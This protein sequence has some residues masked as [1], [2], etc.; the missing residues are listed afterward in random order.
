[1]ILS[2]PEEYMKQKMIYII[3]SIFFFGLQYPI[4][5]QEI[6]VPSSFNPVGSGARAIGM[7]GAFIAV[8]DDATA[9]SWN[10]GGLF[11]LQKPECSMVLYHFHRN[12]DI[13]FG[14]QPEKSGEHG[15]TESNYNFFSMAYPFNFTNRNMVIALSYQRLYDF[16]RNWSYIENI[17][18]K[19]ETA[20]KHWSYLQEGSLSALGLSY[21]IQITPFLSAGLTVNIWDDDITDNHWNQR[22]HTVKKG[23]T[24]FGVPYESTGIKE[25]NF[26]FKG[27]NF[28]IGML[29]SINRQ[30]TIGAVVKSAFKAELMHGIIDLYRSTDGGDSDILLNNDDYLKMPMSW[31]CGVYY[32]ISK[33]LSLSADIYRTEWDDFKLIHENGGQFSPISGL[34]WGQSDVKPTHQIRTG[35]EYRIFDQQRN[36]IIPIRAGLFYDPAPAEGNPDDYIGF[37][38]GCGYHLMN[39]FSFDL[40]YQYRQGH[41]VGDSILKHLNFSQ[42]LKEHTLYSSIIVYF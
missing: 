14:N 6:E 18:S 30:L 3:I 12:E 16:Y 39:T 23:Q 4:F 21:C 8:A 26:E 33:Q 13:S 19:Y 17:D 15:I 32:R 11:Q 5:A 20:Q 40:A 38:L 24:V 42:D 36:A 35:M 27:Y 9:S 10:P 41:D 37:S 22:Y 29:Y 28:N 34:S 1:M 31:G 7:G 2:K 25:E